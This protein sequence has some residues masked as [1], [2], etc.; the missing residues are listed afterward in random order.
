[1]ADY[2]DKAEQAEKASF[3][4]SNY[5]IREGWQQVARTYR[6]LASRRPPTKEKPATGGAPQTKVSRPKSDH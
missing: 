5:Q 2:L 6:L 4:A 1:M 3:E